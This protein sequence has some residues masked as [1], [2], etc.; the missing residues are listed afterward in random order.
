MLNSTKALNITILIFV[1]VFGVVGYLFLNRQKAP[2]SNLKSEVSAVTGGGARDSA[3]QSDALNQTNKQ[4]LDN[5]TNLKAI[6]LDDSIFKEAAFIGLTDFG[7]KLVP[8]PKGRDNPFA[9]LQSKSK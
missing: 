3:A 8:E 2:E 1:L 5:L 6:T 7:L 4:F 9:P